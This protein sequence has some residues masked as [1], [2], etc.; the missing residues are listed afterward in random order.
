MTNPTHPLTMLER[1]QIDARD[2]YEQN[3]NMSMTLNEMLYNCPRDICHVILNYVVTNPHWKKSLFTIFL[4]LP[5]RCRRV[6]LPPEKPDLLL[7]R[8][9]GASLLF[10]PPD[11]DSAGAPDSGP[12]LRLPKIQR[13]QPDGPG[14]LQVSW[15][16][17]KNRPI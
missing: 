4:Y 6:L 10:T 1:L 7:L 15:V 2:V 8:E 5:Y 9:S 12:K 3:K 17:A 14:I 16:T 11:I 13:T